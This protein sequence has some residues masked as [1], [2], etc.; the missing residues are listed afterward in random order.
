LPA[1]VTTHS[2]CPG[3]DIFIVVSWVSQ[4]QEG[5][6]NTATPHLLY[7]LSFLCLTDLWSSRCWPGWCTV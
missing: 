4:R 3:Q 2:C 6:L 7:T 5:D 1:K